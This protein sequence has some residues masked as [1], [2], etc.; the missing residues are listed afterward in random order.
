MSNRTNCT[1]NQRQF[2]L[3]HLK[4]NDS[5]TTQDFR[6]LGIYAPAPRVKELREL[7]INI[8]TSLERVIDHAGIEHERVARY[9]LSEG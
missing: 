2:I 6:D 5:A 4:D 1:A 9:Y 7:G 8:K 3:T